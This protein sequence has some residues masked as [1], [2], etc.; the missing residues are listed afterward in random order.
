MLREE[1]RLEMSGFR[2]GARYHIAGTLQADENE[3][4]EAPTDARIYRCGTCGEMGHNSRTCV[5][6]DDAPA[7]VETEAEAP[8][9]PATLKFDTL[10]AGVREMGEEMQ[11]LLSMMVEEYENLCGTV[12]SLSDAAGQMSASR[13]AQTQW[14]R[15]LILAFI[16]GRASLPDL[17]SAIAE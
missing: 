15:D 12:E 14:Y 6:V 2:K 11:R 16:E 3:N 4:V 17:A 13:E 9:N 7:E 5:A 10:S 8:S 1:G